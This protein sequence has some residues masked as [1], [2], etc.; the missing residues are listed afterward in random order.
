M[1]PALSELYW[2]TVLSS[3]FAKV[4]VEA[5]LSIISGASSLSEF[6][7]SSRSLFSL[8]S[9]LLKPLSLASGE[10]KKIGFCSFRRMKYSRII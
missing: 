8:S 9:D 4:E 1:S 7:D 3:P 5:R 10:T 2:V 6:L